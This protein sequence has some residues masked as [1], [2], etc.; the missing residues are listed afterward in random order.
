MIKKLQIL[1][2]DG[3]VAEWKDIE[4]EVSPEYPN[5]T[6]QSHFGLSFE[7][8]TFNIEKTDCMGVR[9]IGMAGGSAHFISIAELEVFGVEA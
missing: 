3:D 6:A 8:Y 1:V 4:A 9:L 2:A 7:T 5:G